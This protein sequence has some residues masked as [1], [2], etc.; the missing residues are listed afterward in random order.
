MNY[1]SINKF[2]KA[3]IIGSRAALIAKGAEPMIDPFKY[4]LTDPIEIAL[5]EYK[6]NK[7][8]MILIKPMPLGDSVKLYLSKQKV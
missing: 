8:P 3:R 5:E 7:T 6:Q 1:S 2:E 4:G